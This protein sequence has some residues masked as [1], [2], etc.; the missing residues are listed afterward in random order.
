VELSKTP[1]IIGKSIEE[2]LRN[3]G[4]LY[5]PVYI[6]ILQLVRLTSR[7][8]GQ[9]ARLTVHPGSFALQP[10]ETVSRNK[11]REQLLISKL[12]KKS[13]RRFRPVLRS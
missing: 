3:V 10:I 6:Q 1:K 11:Y 5:G 7:C 13:A 8:M 2:T 4:V 9:A 12:F